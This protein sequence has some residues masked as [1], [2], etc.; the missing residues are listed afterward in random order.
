MSTRRDLG[1]SDGYGCLLLSLMRL[2]S[3]GIL[4]ADV[5]MRMVLTSSPKRDGSKELMFCFAWKSHFCDRRNM[6]G[7]GK[8]ECNYDGRYGTEQGRSRGRPRERL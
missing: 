6:R 5:S 7:F 4:L 2:V 8:C 1:N 3:V